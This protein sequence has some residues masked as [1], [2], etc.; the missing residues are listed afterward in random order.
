MEMKRRRFSLVELLLVIGIIALLAALLL[1][2]LRQAKLMALSAQCQGNLR[3][4]GIALAGYADDFNGWVIGC[5]CGS[6]NVAYP[7]LGGMMMGLGYTPANPLYG[8]LLDDFIPFGAVFQCPSLPPP[9]S[10][11]HGGNNFPYV[12]RN[13]RIAQSFGLRGMNSSYLY[14]GEQVPFSGMIRFSSLYQP[15]KLPY[16]VDTVTPANAIGGGASPGGVQTSNWYLNTSW[17][18]DIHLRHHKRAN[19]WCPDGHVGVWGLSDLS[20][21]RAPD[22]NVITFKY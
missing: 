20:E 16:M 5:E 3:Q 12:G 17:G 15:S 8:S 6:T 7:R 9:A 18:G 10:Y 13:S 4:S 21:W 22:N 1:P 14:S 19:V 2:A 11:N